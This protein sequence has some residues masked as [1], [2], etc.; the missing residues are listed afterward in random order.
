MIK[1]IVACGRNGV[2]GFNN[3]MPWHLPR[4]LKFF[5]EKTLNQTVIMGRKTYE[6]IGKALP[7]R[8]NIILSRQNLS[9]PN[10]EVIY[11][12]EEALI[13]AESFQ[14][15]IFIIGGAEIYRQFLSLADV[16]FKTEIQ[17]EFVGD[18]HFP[19]LSEALWRKVSRDFYPADE[20]NAYDLAFVEYHR[21]S[22]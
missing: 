11:S 17:A 18:A 4:D 7:Q 22:A 9:V 8:N 5:K 1:I 6:S 13:R 10:A 16:V 19:R 21:R 12:R 2:I 20:K 15:D 3:Q 14:T